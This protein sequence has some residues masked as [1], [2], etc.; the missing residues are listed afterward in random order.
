MDGYAVDKA[1][2]GSVF[3]GYRNGRVA[4]VLLGDS[5]DDVVQQLEK[6]FPDVAVHGP[7]GDKLG[8]ARKIA[9]ILEGED[10]PPDV[11]IDVN[12]TPFQQAVWNVIRSIP[13]GCTQT[14][15]HVAAKIG[16]PKAVRAVAS[17]CGANPIAVLVPC[18][19]VVRADGN[20]QGYAWGM[21]RKAA[22]LERERIGRCQDRHGQTL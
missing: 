20:G 18:H 2:I 22:L 21:D 5:A 16:K 10:L 3:V 4:A 14:Y 6:R 11:P 7:C 1:E 17:A 19:R 8:I 9:A 12:G 13:W 15:G